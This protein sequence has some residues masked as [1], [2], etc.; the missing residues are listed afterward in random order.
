MDSTRLLPTQAEQEKRASLSETAA[1]GLALFSGYLRILCML[2]ALWPACPLARA[3]EPAPKPPSPWELSVQYLGLTWHPDGGNTPEVYPLKLDRKAYLVLS[4]GAAVNLDYRLTDA[5]FVRLTS[6]L[7][8]DCA[9]L[10][11]GC[12]HAGPRLECSWSGNR[13]NAGVGPI[14]SF[15]RDWHRFEEYEDDEFYGDRVWRGWQYRLFW[16]AVELEYLRRISDS[17]EFQWSI[18]PGAPLVITSMVGVRF[19]PG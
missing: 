15:R 8:K 2:A 19:R 18:I 5:F 10:T 11:A 13:V 4:V 14:L 1:P 9:F 7:Y 12:I 16:S 17:I 6:S 3:V